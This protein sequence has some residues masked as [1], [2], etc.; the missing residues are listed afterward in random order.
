MWHNRSSYHTLFHH[1][2]MLPSGSVPVTQRWTSLLILITHHAH[3]PR[4]HPIKSSLKN[5]K[6]PGCW[7]S[8]CLPYTVSKFKSSSIVHTVKNGYSVRSNTILGCQKIHLKLSLS[9]AWCPFLRTLKSQNHFPFSS[10]SVPPQKAPDSF[11]PY[12][13]QG[14]ENKGVL[15]K[16]YSASLKGKLGR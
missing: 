16:S 1:F 6:M 7:V 9:P 14:R 3:P 12:Q 10:H 8:D 4:K 13:L 11:G 2:D 5:I 15:W